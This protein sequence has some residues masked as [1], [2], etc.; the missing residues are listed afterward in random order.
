MDVQQLKLL[1]GRVRGLLEQ[2]GASL[3]HGQSLDLIAALAGLRNW[4]EVMAFPDRVAVCEADGVAVARLARRLQHQC[5]LEIG[6]DVVAGA[7]QAAA[8]APAPATQI[9]PGGPRPGVYVTDSQAAINALLARYEEATDGAL[10]YA[11]RAGDHADGSIDLGESGLWSR[12]LDRVPS[13]TLLVVGPLELTQ[14]SWSESASRLEMA[15]LRAGSSGHRVA[16]LVDTPT[17]ETMCNDLDLMVRSCGPEGADNGAVLV[18]VVTEDGELQ[19]H[20][21]FARPLAPPAVVPSAVILEA[22]PATLLPALR[23]AL[24][25]RKTGLVVLGATVRSEHPAIDLVAATIALTEHAG[26]AARIKPRNR[27]TPAKDMM[28]PDAV[29]ALPFLPSIESAYAQGYRRLIVESGYT[30][31]ELLHDYGDE[32]LFIVGV[33]GLDVGDVF[34]NACRSGG[35]DRLR[36]L[37]AQVVAVVGVGQIE[38]KG[39]VV[40]VSDLYLPSEC[41]PAGD[42]DFER[43]LDHMLRNRVL[44]WEDELDELLA[45]R[46]ISVASIKKS[47]PRECAVNDF[48]A[49]RAGR[50][51]AMAG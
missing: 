31:T 1:A 34:L 33:H 44:R 30:G 23:Q 36:E 28:V 38:G 2:H 3:S 8:G 12:G 6:T 37:L 49:T 26:P 24:A 21:P 32:V 11:E 46:R 14:Q 45:A 20:V 18:G 22:V 48:L 39:G 19:R 17:P 13:G 42:R 9:W 41:D 47:F 35:F 40:Q 7:L 51:P 15:C 27:G 50:R 43:V 4:P 10:V 16:V 29:K 5:G 25:G